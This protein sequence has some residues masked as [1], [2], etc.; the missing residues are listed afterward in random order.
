MQRWSKIVRMACSSAAM[1]NP[2][3]SNASSR[4]FLLRPC[5]VC[6]T[7]RNNTPNCIADMRKGA[8]FGLQCRTCAIAAVALESSKPASTTL[9]FCAQLKQDT[10]A[11]DTYTALTAPRAAVSCSQGCMFRERWLTDR[12]SSYGGAPGQGSTRTAFCTAHTGVRGGGVPWAHGR[13]WKQVCYDRGLSLSSRVGAH[14]DACG[15]A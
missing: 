9:A 12:S 13:R 3:C 4:T 8:R 14:A 10:C 2:S 6:S 15:G 11:L 7:G 1:R 5:I